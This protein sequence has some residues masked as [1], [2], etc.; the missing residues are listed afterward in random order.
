VNADLTVSELRS[1]ARVDPQT[2]K[3]LAEAV[4]GR[5]L[6]VRGY[7]RVLRVA[8]TAADLGASAAL[9]PEDVA[10]ALLMRGDQ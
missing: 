4:R 7:H 10:L 3:L 8:R 2:E 9:R 5:R 1:H 6:S